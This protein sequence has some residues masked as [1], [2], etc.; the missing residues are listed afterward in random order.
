MAQ[1]D[2]SDNY[3]VFTESKA[4][5]EAII[6]Y[7]TAD[8]SVFLDGANSRYYAEL[9]YYHGIKQ[10][11][12]IAY[13]P[14]VSG[15]FTKL[16]Q[17]VTALPYSVIPASGVARTKAAIHA[18]YI[19]DTFDRINI[20]SFY[21]DLLFAYITGVVAHE[22]VWAKDSSGKP[23]LIKLTAVPPEYMYPTSTGL[24][25]LETVNST[26]LLAKNPSKFSIFTYSQFIAMSPLGDGVGKVVY[27]LLKEREKLDCLS[28]LFAVRGATPT[29]VLSATDDVKASTVRSTI[30]AL[31]KNESWKNIALPP[32]LS[33]TNLSNTA[34][35]DIYELL[36]KLNQAL[37]V[38]QLA[39]EGI[40]GTDGVSGMRGAQE[41]SNLR[42]TRATKLAIGAVA[43]IN[44]DLIRPLIDYKFGKQSSYPTFQYALPRLTKLGMASI[45][46]AISV[47]NELGYQVNPTW[48]ETE[49]SLDIIAV[50]ADKKA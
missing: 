24:E 9:G 7:V 5:Q 20:G 8:Q 48:F 44:R 34:K 35:Y 19:E 46:E 49:Y 16:T 40:V 6:S 14:V 17:E 25:F 23:T 50:G 30:N 10:L 15:S 37:I 22:K 27:Y 4:L 11:Y 36:L 41:A 2:L 29:V 1:I 31:N 18:R 12:N 3:D 28:K 43:H 32:G 21:E 39:G 42:K 13:H 38:D 47:Q 33:L 26:K 45:S